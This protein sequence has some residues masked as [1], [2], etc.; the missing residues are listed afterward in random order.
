MGLSNSAQT[1]QRV[2]EHVLEGVE[3]CFIYLDDILVYNVDKKSHIKTLEEIFVKLKEAGLA[4]A[5]GK[6]KF[7]VTKIDYLGYEV[8]SAGIR[9]LGAKV[10]A[11]ARFPA[12]SKQKELLHF[13]GALNYF[14][15]SL[16]A[17]PPETSTGK[18]RSAA[19]ILQP[20]YHLATCSIAKGTTFS[21]IW[22]N[23]PKIVKAFDDAKSLLTRAA[24][25]NFPDPTAPIALTCDASLTAMGATLE[26]K[27]GGVWSPLGFWSKGFK[28]DK[29]KW[30]SFRRETY[31][32]QQ[33][34][35]YF[36]DDI[37][38]R[39]VVVF[40]DCKALVQAFQSNSSQ[41]YDPKAKAHLVEIG[42][43]TK[44]LRHIEAKD[45]Q[46]ADYLSR[47]ETMGENYKVPAAELDVEAL[48]EISLQTLNPR[49][50]AESQA[51][52][53]EVK[54]HQNG[55]L[56][57]KVKMGF[58]EV[59]GIKLY[60]E[61]SSD[62]RPMVPKELRDIIMQSF[63][64]LGHPSAKESTRRISEFYYWPGMK[65]E[66]KSF[67]FSCHPCQ[68]TKSTKKISPKIG[69]FPLPDRRFSHLHLDIV[70]PLPESR[71]FKF[72]LSI[73]DRDSRYFEAIPMTEATAE[74]TCHAFLHGWV[75]RY[76]LP[77]SACSDNGGNFVSKL[78]TDL[79]KTLNIKVQFVPYY[80]QATNGI[81]ERAHG[82]IKAGLK[83]MLLEMG[84]THR[85][86][87]YLH[88]PWV[89]LSRRVA[90]HPDLGVSTS[91]MVLG[92]D[93][94]VP[95]QL[96]GDPTP[97][98]VA[99]DIKKLV[100]HLEAA[101]DRTPIPTSNHAVPKKEYMP[102]STET[103]THVYIKK[104]NPKGLLQKYTG[105]HKIVERPS[106]STIKV[107]IGTFKSGIENIQTHHW[108]NAKPAMM[109]EGAEEGVMP[110]RGRPKKS[111]DQPSVIDPT[112]QSDVTNTTDESVGE[113]EA[114][115]PKTGSTKKEKKVNNPTRRSE[116]I[117]KQNH[118]TSI[119][120]IHSLSFP[121][122]EAGNLNVVNRPMQAWTASK[123]QLRLINLSISRNRA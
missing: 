123:D 29:Q 117:A 11:I 34:L 61:V 77:T 72:L 70:G 92:M 100:S 28:P 68:A 30:T 80:H 40:S 31:A 78:W 3:N 111:K 25:L 51:R 74:A 115:T 23:S 45:N 10:D 120:E 90:L 91:Q 49:A 98:M 2:A 55:N 89:L 8:S 113:S 86:D 119:A 43:W 21:E 16:G 94:V 59:Q 81:V 82:T 88:L 107:K 58:H 95:G 9:P 24:S 6:C 83:A 114:A 64:G 104:E 85:Q 96:V 1:F 69:K 53:E 84:D 14:R 38:G 5:P 17:L 110:T 57:D 41:D 32:V 121:P 47:A 71:G 67:V 44:D 20:L 54:A 102:P 48:E 27:V 33:A 97:P 37:A 62:P 60:C 79:Q 26:Q 109:R 7:G 39:H 106:P 101:S 50:L 52:C 73:F 93:P 13:L 103:A 42:Q 99:G 46:M 56:P 19:E 118:Q 18:K 22:K 35:R 112:A 63:H 15:G 65:K 116:R 12:P 105:P 75:A 66:I 122:A 108:A 4:I 87:W 76:G 36:L